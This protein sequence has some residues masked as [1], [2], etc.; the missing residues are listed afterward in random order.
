M[1]IADSIFPV[2]EGR[3]LQVLKER[4]G[5]GADFKQNDLGEIMS[6]I[7]YFTGFTPFPFDRD[8]F[9]MLEKSPLLLDQTAGFSMWRS[10]SLSGILQA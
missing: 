9:N 3:S 1:P 8:P 2:T 6:N 5:T 10:R 4:S 7:R